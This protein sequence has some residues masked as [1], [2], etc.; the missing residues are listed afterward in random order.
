MKKIITMALIGVCSSFAFAGVESIRQGGYRYDKINPGS[1]TLPSG[2]STSITSESLKKSIDDKAADNEANAA[3]ASKNASAIEV[4]KGNITSTN[5][6]I[7]TLQGQYN[8]HETRIRTLE[9]K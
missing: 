4:N 3:T 5:N 1:S 8:G 9:A 7:S 2:G 6:S